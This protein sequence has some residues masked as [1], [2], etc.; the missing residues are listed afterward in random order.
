MLFSIVPL[1][2]PPELRLVFFHQHQHA[3]DRG[4]AVEPQPDHV[5]HDPD[6]VVLIDADDHQASLVA[7]CCQRHRM[8]AG[9]VEAHRR[10]CAGRSFIEL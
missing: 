5:G 4:L 7:V 8:I 2:G 10:A 3:L 6:V 1:L 9:A